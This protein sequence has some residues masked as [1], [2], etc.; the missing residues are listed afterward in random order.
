[1]GELLIIGAGIG[2]Y[3]I[4]DKEVE[5]YLYN[6]PENGATDTQIRDTLLLIRLSGVITVIQDSGGFQFNMAEENGWEITSNPLEPASQGKITNIA[7]LHLIRPA[8]IIRPTVLIAPDFP[9][10][11]IKKEELNARE[12]E[13]MKKLG[14][15]TSW[16]IETRRRMDENNLDD[17]MFYVPVQAYNIDQ[18]IRFFDAIN[19]VNFDGVCMPTRNMDEVEIALFL[20]L[21]YQ[22]GI[23]RVH[24]LGTATFLT[25]AVAAFFASL[26]FDHVI[27]DATTW[28]RTAKVQQYLNPH[29]LKPELLR[30]DVVIDE[31]I[32]NDCPCP[33]CREKT[34]T[35]IRNEPY[36]DKY[37]SLMQHNF[38]VTVNAAKQLYNNANSLENLRRHMLM[39]CRDTERVERLCRALILIEKLKD[40]NIK[41][42]ERQ[43]SRI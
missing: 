14:F 20:V 5:G 19:S 17:I 30:D 36:N 24:L 26:V 40:T 13:F 34:F 15:N 8:K 43:L 1:M 38:W 33:F 39:N 32:Q 16:T 18:G 25:F 37:F 42:L 11:K 41:V 12:M 6:V 21:F 22:L 27:L 4:P 9:I 7:P 3:S 31:R 2:P 23:R 28:R 10:I 29:D 35:S